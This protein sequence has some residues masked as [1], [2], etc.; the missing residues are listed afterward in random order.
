MTV[1]KIYNKHYPGLEKLPSWEMEMHMPKLD[2]FILW[3]KEWK[4]MIA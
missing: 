1:K 4:K 2:I 3:A